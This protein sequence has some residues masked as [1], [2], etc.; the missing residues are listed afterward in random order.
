MGDFFTGQTGGGGRQRA[1]AVGLVGGLLLVLFLAGAAPPTSAAPSD[2]APNV[3][4]HLPE[5]TVDA[6][7]ETRLTLQ[8]ENDAHPADRDDPADILVARSTTINVTDDGPFT[9]TT[10]EQSVGTLEP[11]VV[12]PAEIGVTVPDDVEPGT[13]DLEIAINHSNVTDGSTDITER[14]ERTE[15]VTVVVRD[16]PRF[17]VDA[18][19]TTAR[20]GTDG[21]MTVEVENLGNE[22]ARDVIVGLESTSERVGFGPGEELLP[23][24][25]ASIDEL[26][27]GDV[28][29]LTYDI[30]VVPGAAEQSYGF[31]AT[32]EYV[33]EAGIARTDRSPAT[34][35]IPLADGAFDVEVVE[36]TVQVGERGAVAIEVENTAEFAV[37]DLTVELTTQ[38]ERLSFGGPET[39]TPA[40]T[41][42]IAT[43]GA[44]ESQV[45]TFDVSVDQETSPRE[46]GLDAAIGY[47][48]PDGVEGVVDDATIG[49]EPSD[50]QSF[51]VTDVAA[52]VRPGEPGTVTAT[53]VNEGPLPVQDVS[54]AIDAGL[55]EPRSPTQAIGDLD[56]GEETEITIRGI[57][58]AE[59][60]AVDQHLDLVMDYETAAG[61][62]GTADA[63]TQVPVDERRDA[64]RAS[65][66]NASFD[67]GEERLL[68]I[69]LENQRDI[70]VR[71]VRVDLLPE[72]PVE[73]D[74]PRTSVTHLDAGTSETVGIL[75]EIDDDA[76]PTTFPVTL[77]IEYLDE[78]DDRQ[79]VRAQMVTLSVTDDPDEFLVGVEVIVFV[80]LIILVVA[81]L[82][83]LYRR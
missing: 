30:A 64:V 31:D 33:D 72:E 36:S 39:A 27:P 83:W 60:D 24:D 2:G 69:E 20:I 44:G 41:A 57:L 8:V 4:V 5:P 54:V 16:R 13:Y 14:H 6:G 75:I 49:I 76:P 38:S 65:A 23:A 37:S 47:E 7:E 46:F 10:A 22:T 63:R 40:D 66:V 78:Q 17:D 25:S 52:S 19:E 45:I 55:F 68:E 28:A 70:D 50:E 26:Q 29:T 12:R 62:D 56:A 3:T 35:V 9:V 61:F 77:E 59:A 80:I 32:V 34:S 71:D 79:T 21:T 1:L 18:V 74:F 53:I 42:R 82:V 58:P 15:N 51:A 73:S 81:V 11:G 48:G 43:L 67:P